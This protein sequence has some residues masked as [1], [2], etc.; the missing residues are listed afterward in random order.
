MAKMPSQKIKTGPVLGSYVYLLEPRQ[1][2][3]DDEAKG[4]KPEYSICLLWDEN[5]PSLAAI[6]QAVVN[7]ATQ[8]FGKAAVE[9]LKSGKIK[10]PLHRGDVDRP[11]DENFK[12]KVYLN[13]KSTR[14]VGVVDAKLQPVFERS[15]CYSGCTF[16]A[17]LNIAAYDHPAGGKGVTAYLNAVQVLKRGK[18]ID[19]HV[20]ASK[21][22]EEF[23]DAGSAE[24]SA[25][26]D[27]LL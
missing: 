25:A 27:D 10:N 24:D 15:E 12:G 20:D 5:D 11:E 9:Q 19:G 3:A 7:V 4:K 26:L 17:S 18:R 2:N 6:K 23:V 13:A 16:R 8:A 21:E 1:P 22:F 14:P